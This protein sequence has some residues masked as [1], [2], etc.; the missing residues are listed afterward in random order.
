MQEEIFGP[1]WP[2]FTF[3]TKEEAKHIIDKNPNPLAF[4]LF[5]K[6]S[7]SKWWMENLA[8]G[9]GCINNTLF[10]ITNPKLPFGGA[11]NSGMG[12]YHGKYSFHTFTHSKSVLKSPNWFGPA[13]KYPPFKG[14]LK[15]LKILLR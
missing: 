7:L 10:H 15:W 3:D 5:T 13:L 6:G 8:F 2:I 14:K 12:A 4:Y 1:I 11:G 9:G